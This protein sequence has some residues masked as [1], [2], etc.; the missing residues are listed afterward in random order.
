LA[1]A[2]LD[3]VGAELRI[4]LA[5]PLSRAIIEHEFVSGITDVVTCE[6]DASTG[7]VRAEERRMLGAILLR[8][9]AIADADAG[10]AIRAT[11]ARYVREHPDVLTP[12]DAARSLQERIA[13]ARRFDASI[14]DRSMQQIIEELDDHLVGVTSVAQVQALPLAD[15][16]MRSLTWEQRTAVDALAPATFETPTKRVVRIDYSD[17]ERP[18]ISV[19]LQDMFGVNDTPR[20]GGGRQVL[21]V[22][23]LSPAGRPI[24]IT[25]DLGGFW[26]GSYAEVRK[27]MKGRYPKH[28]W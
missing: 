25:Q 12:N 26:N 24:Q 7:R 16:I 28:Q 21:T 19:R 14:P 17:A 15:I 8:S 4:A 22:A 6:L 13:F 11:L 5:A 3:S 9:R 20:I 2:D 18:M 10:D 1:I 27:E 23:L